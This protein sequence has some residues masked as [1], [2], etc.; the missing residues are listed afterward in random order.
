[1]IENNKE[2]Y[3][4]HISNGYNTYFG[5][6]E[7]FAS[8]DLSDSNSNSNFDFELFANSCAGWYFDTCNQIRTQG[9]GILEIISKSKFIN[10][11][12]LAFTFTS[13]REKKQNYVKNKNDFFLKLSEI[14]DKK[15]F[16]MHII[17][18]YKYSGDKI[19]LNCKSQQHMEFFI[20]RIEKNF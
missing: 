13:S 16:E 10:H 6:L 1:M 18:N 20:C 11:S 8:G 5:K 17:K 15:S 7:D 19:F 9:K 14:L 3:E 4:S 12:I 2:N